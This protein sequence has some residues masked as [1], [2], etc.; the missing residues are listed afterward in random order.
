EMD[1]IPPEPVIRAVHDAMTRGDTG[2]EGDHGY[3]E[4]FASFADE[5]WGWAVD[6]AAAR[7]VPD[8]M[9]GIEHLLRLLTEPG[10][11]VVIAPPV[12]P[13]FRLFAEHAG[14]RVVTAPLTPAGRL[15]FETLDRAFGIAKS[16]GHRAVFLLCQPHNPTGVLHTADELATL[17]A[18]A[19]DWRVRVVADEIHAALI[20]P[21]PDGTRPVFTPTTAVIPDAIAL[22]SASKTF[23]IAGLKAAVAVPGPAAPELTML[24]QLASDGVSHVASLAHQAGFLHGGPWLDRLLDAIAG[25]IGFVGRLLAQRLPVVRWIPPEATYLAWLDLRAAG[26][27]GGAAPADFLVNTARVALN[28]GANFGVEGDGFVRFNLAASRPVLHEAIARIAAALP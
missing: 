15:D 4:A 25:N 20:A 24:P 26:V 23:N 8:V 17:G 10:D 22:H 6:P 11:T 19:A 27:P 13:P 12:Y 14:R 21:G 16:G 1:V 18:L 2:Y 28:D 3:V 9:Q 7:L 5:R